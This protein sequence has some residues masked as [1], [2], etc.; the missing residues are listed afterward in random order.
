MN[1]TPILPDGVINGCEKRN[2]LFIIRNEYYTMAL[3]LEIS[4]LRVVRL[5]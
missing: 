5:S 4:I 3:I 1:F 2:T